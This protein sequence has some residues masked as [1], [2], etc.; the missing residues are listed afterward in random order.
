MDE[1]QISS[2]IVEGVPSGMVV[3]EP[4]E[5]EEDEGGESLR[6][7][8]PTPKR[9]TKAQRNKATRLLAEVLSHFLVRYAHFLLSP[10]SFRNGRWR[11]KRPKNECRRL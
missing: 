2:V 8:K 6:V 10:D 9:K 1:A 11:R 4:G 7:I 3:D 5:S